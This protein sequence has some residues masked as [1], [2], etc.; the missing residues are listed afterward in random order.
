MAAAAFSDQTRRMTCKS[1]AMGR[2]V[3]ARD[4]RSISPARCRWRGG[5]S[6]RHN[7]HD[8]HRHPGIAERQKRRV[9]GKGQRRAISRLTVPSRELKEDR[10]MPHEPD[11][12]RKAFGHIAPA[13]GDYTDN[14]LFGDLWK[15]PQL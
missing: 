10:S 14:V 7:R 5:P 13:L 6:H 9:A 15:R 12:A 2:K 1:G 8:A 3:R 4:R 11:N